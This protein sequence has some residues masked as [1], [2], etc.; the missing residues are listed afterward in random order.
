MPNYDYQCDRCD[1]TFEVRASFKEKETGLKPVCPSCQST[2]TH[3]LLSVG[4]FVHAGATDGVTSSSCCGPSA[5]PGC[6]G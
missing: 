5:G 1:T 2:E 6:C 3:Q 4:M